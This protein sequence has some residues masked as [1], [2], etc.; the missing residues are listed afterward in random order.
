M[1]RERSLGL[2]A[3]QGEPDHD[4]PLNLLLHL[5]PL[6]HLNAMDIAHTREFLI[7]YSTVWW[8]AVSAYVLERVT[9]GGNHSHWL[10]DR[11]TRARLFFPT[12]ARL[13]ANGPP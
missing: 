10:F 2:T 13:E 3:Q 5:R 12:L 1:Q 9:F 7:A 11:I 4:P 6:A 8:F